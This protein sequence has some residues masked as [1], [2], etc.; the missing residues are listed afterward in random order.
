[1]LPAASAVVAAFQPHIVLATV[2]FLTMAAALGLAN[3]TVF[4]L[5][6]TQVPRRAGGGVT[7]LV[8]AAGTPGRG[9]QALAPG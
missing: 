2:A 5:V 1:M 9:T 7:G 8:W 4:A 6:G 3:G